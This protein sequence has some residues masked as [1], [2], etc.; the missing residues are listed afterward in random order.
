MVLTPGAWDQSP[1]FFNCRASG[2]AVRLRDITDPGDQG[3]GCRLEE[4]HQVKDFVLSQEEQ[5]YRFKRLVRGY[6]ASD[7]FAINSIAAILGLSTRTL[8]RKLATWGMSFSAVLDDQRMEVAMQDLGSHTLGMTAIARKLG[9]KHA[10]DFT[11]AFKRRTKMTPTEYRNL[12]GGGS[13]NT[14]PR[15]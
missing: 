13:A 10:G 9:Y 4:R 1:F 15:L 2:L 12:A 14:G 6:L 7:D 5:I 11:R 8:Q 3:V